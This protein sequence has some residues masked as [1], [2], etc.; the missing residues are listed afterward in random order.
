MWVKPVLAL[1]TLVLKETDSYAEG[2][3]GWNT[4]YTYISVVYNI[5]ICLSL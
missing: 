1:V 4:G 2:E 5:S 3:L